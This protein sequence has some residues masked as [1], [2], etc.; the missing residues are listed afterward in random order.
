MLSKLQVRNTGFLKL[1]DFLNYGK[2]K[3]VSQIISYSEVAVV[4]FKI[5]CS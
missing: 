5:G 3:K 2:Q 4:L 1:R